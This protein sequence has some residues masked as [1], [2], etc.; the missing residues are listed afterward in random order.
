M[1]SPIDKIPEM[2]RQA[3][4]CGFVDGSF[5]ALQRIAFG[6]KFDPEAAMDEAW[7]KSAAR[8]LAEIFNARGVANG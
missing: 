8:Q 4:N 7:D 5:A 1:E 3:F 2:M 6:N